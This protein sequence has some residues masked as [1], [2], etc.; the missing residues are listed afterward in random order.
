[1]GWNKLLNLG[2]IFVKCKWYWWTFYLKVK[3]YRISCIFLHTLINYFL[4]VSTSLIAQKIN[5]TFLSLKY[6]VYLAG[7]GIESYFIFAFYENIFDSRES[8]VFWNNDIKF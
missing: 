6:V 5:Y 4:H 7:V 8:D 1:M 3:V 2:N